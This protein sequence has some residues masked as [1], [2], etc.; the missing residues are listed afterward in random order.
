MLPPKSP[1]EPDVARDQEVVAKLQQ[2]LNTA[3]RCASAETARNYEI[4]SEELQ[5]L[6]SAV[7]HSC[8]SHADCR[9]LLDNLRAG[10]SLSAEEMATLRLMIVGDADY[11]LKYDEEFRRCN[12]DL[13][14]LLSEL[15]GFEAD[16]L[17][18]DGLMHLDVLCQDACKML[19]M[20]GHYLEQ[21]DRVRSFEEATQGPLDQ[22]TGRSLAT[23]ISGMVSA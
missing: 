4:L 14:R 9:S 13:H 19:T 20:A 22:E 15:K 3:A 5:D 7:T 11:Y 6:R 2:A 12:D 16:E 1:R 21:R 18:L 10:N 17:D 8:R 23:V